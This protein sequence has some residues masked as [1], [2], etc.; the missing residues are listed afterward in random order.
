MAS[1]RLDPELEA[2]VARAA[3]LRGESKSDFIRHALAER[4]DA[5]LAAS[6]AERVAHLVGAVDLG[7]EVAG[8]AREAAAELIEREHLA[9]V[10]AWQSRR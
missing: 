2:R 7:G 3:A 10:A 9:Q 5:T 6:P 4:V 1:V 8:R